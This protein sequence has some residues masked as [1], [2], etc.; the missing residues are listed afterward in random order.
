M[1]GIQ[2]ALCG[3]SNFAVSRHI[4]LNFL[5]QDKT[6]KLGTQNKRLKAAGDQDYPVRLLAQ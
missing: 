2:Q 3:V 6:P 5:T 4:A 1:N